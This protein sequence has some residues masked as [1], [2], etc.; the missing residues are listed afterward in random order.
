MRCPAATCPAAP[1]ARAAAQEAS[2]AEV[3]SLLGVATGAAA[4]LLRA[5]KWNREDLL[6]R[7]MEDPDK[8]RAAGASLSARRRPAAPP[9]RRVRRARADTAHPR[10]A[11][12]V[13]REAGVAA[14]C[15]GAGA[16][17]ASAAPA[18]SQSECAICRDDASSVSAL[19]CGH[20]YCDTCW[21]TYLALKIA[22]GD[23]RIG[24]PAP[25]CCLRVPEELVRRLCPGDVAERF[26]HFLRNSF[27][28]DSANAAWCPVPGCGQAVRTGAAVGGPGA[29][30]A[31]G[32]GVFVTCGAGHAFCAACRAEAHAP[33]SC[34]VVKAWLQKA[35]DDSETANWLSS[36]TQDCPAC[37]A[38]IEK[39]GGCNHMTCKKCRHEFCWV[40][41][42]TWASH[43]DF[44]S[45]NKFDA[46]AQ[47]AKEAGKA[48]SRAALDRYLFHFHRFANHEHSRKLEAQ[49]RVAAEAKVRALQEGAPGGGRGWSDVAFVQAGCEEALACRALLKWTYV[50]AYALPE[51]APQRELFCYLQQDLEARTERL[52]GLLESDAPTL[53]RPEVRAEILALV[54]VAAGARK[55]LLRGVADSGLAAWQAGVGA[56]EAAVGDAPA[57]GGG[58]AGGS[59]AEAAAA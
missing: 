15:D 18:P 8:A 11:P 47:T 46:A 37:S 2:V 31:C 16:A 30:A 43:T 10:P 9:R 24:C 17:L 51:E 1:Q 36:H 33:A 14:P 55:K 25:K 45:C 7:Y 41:A 28:D 13:S 35:A 22:D 21:A 52:S 59:G 29:A 42:G 50:L 54:G 44:Y 3:A 53:A 39:N 48:S 40:C 56:A 27:V 19:H 26:A 34:A 6:T 23:T 12:Q 38:T 57:E 49:T 20:A 5:F 58:G 4:L 32:A